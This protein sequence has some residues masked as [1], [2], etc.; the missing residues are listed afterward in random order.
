MSLIISELFTVEYC[1]VKYLWPCV[2]NGT[3]PR[4]VYN[5]KYWLINKYT[6]GVKGAAE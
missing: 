1:K 6:I 2:G 5:L 3:F 4:C